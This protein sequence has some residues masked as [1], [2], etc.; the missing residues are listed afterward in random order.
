MSGRGGAPA[1]AERGRA[2][3]PRLAG[4]VASG[5][6]RL[7]GSA[8]GTAIGFGVLTFACALAVV[9]GPRASAQLRTTAF[10]Q[11]VAS[12][13]ALDKTIVGTLEAGSLGSDTQSQIGAAVLTRV[14]AKLRGNLAK[15][16]PLAAARSDWVGVTTPL[17]GF[18]DHSPAVAAGVGTQFELVYRDDL[19]R[20]VRVLAGSLPAA[21]AHRSGSAVVPIAITAATARRYALKV[22]SCVALPGTSIE[23]QVTAIV[24]PASAET[25]FWQL[26]PLVAAPVLHTPIGP[27]SPAAPALGPDWQGGAFVSAAA[28]PAVTGA[29]S[30]S[31]TQVTW[32]FGLALGHLTGTR[33]VSLAQSFPVTLGTAGSL[34][35]L[36][37]TALETGGVENVALTSGAA[38]ILGPFAADD[39]A[40][41]NVLDLMTVSLA[42]VGAAIVLLTAW[43][44]A[45]KR[46]EEFAVLR[47]RGASRRQLAVAALWGS[48]IAAGPG[49]AVGI[50]AGLALTAG[51]A[52]P[53]AWW[54]AGG[55]VAVALA[56]PVVIT[57][58]M[59]RGYAGVTRPDRPM[60]RI[61]S[62]RR[63]VAEVTLALAAVGGLV[64]LRHAGAG[65]AG[66][67]L[68]ASTAPVLVA[69]PVAVILLR[70]Y[71]LLLRP[72]LLLA[73][74][75]PGVT[76][77]LGLARA[78]RVSATAVLPAFAMVLAFSLV[79]F[80]GMVRGAVIRSEVAQSWQQAGADA[81][82]TVPDALS[83]AQQRAIAA[84]PGVQRTVAV[85]LTTAAKG[86]GRNAI[87]ALVADPA[88]YA[89]L[90]AGSP[91]NPVPASYANWHGVADSA[92]A[93]SAAAGQGSGGHSGA[94]PVLA[95]ASVA[96]ELGR[97]PTVLQLQDGQRI[98]VYVAGVAPAMS[99]VASIS[100]GG[101]AGYVVLPR[102][103]LHGFYVPPVSSLLVAGPDLDSRALTATVSKWHV[104]GVQVVVRSKL[105]AA[106]ER[107]PVEHDAYSELAVGG[108]AAAA[109]SLLVLLLTLLLSARSRELT[110]ARTATMGMSA[111]QARWLVLVEALPQIL[112]V[113]AGGLVCALALAPLVGPALA[114]SEFTGSGAAVPVRIEPAWL[115]AA[116]IGLLVLA[117]ATLTGQTALASRGVARSLRIGE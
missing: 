15:G 28:L 65:Q 99:A 50:A 75:R 40:V 89:A 23:L 78:A 6:R 16:A 88:Q 45:E 52:A 13:P 46:R 83:A 49:A 56:G 73:G 103:A 29:F 51:A 30:P 4:R 33:A 5:W 8:S 104:A 47:A 58:R 107:A 71:P 69:I 21:V 108:Y 72:L 53:L 96:A 61:A 90:L 74:R 43:L 14:G 41:G 31:E 81:V 62:V 87:N 38:A 85:G 79:S 20:H 17:A 10:R 37:Q 27:P 19:S 84:V 68:Y 82:V 44:M 97:G 110:L 67:D 116:A 94:V 102:S 7:A 63:L 70:L 34:G 101:S 48:V 60:R 113:L 92:S 93:D 64:V 12:A 105:L 100:G 55:T 114:L 112:S 115:A 25:S 3:S 98:A 106:L 35:G 59:H 91:V 76:A 36:S 32:V 117:I 26:D 18:A 2:R 9:A 86:F 66:G 109:G 111:A 1:S 42:V 57:V 54:L 80:A 11:L 22:G 95:S 39:G 24:A 77:F